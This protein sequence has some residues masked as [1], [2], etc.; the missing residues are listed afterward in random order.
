MPP[1]ASKGPEGLSFWWG[2]EVLKLDLWKC[3][4][5]HSG[6]G[7]FYFLNRKVMQIKEV[8]NICTAAKK[9]KYMILVLCL[10][11]S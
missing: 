11:T 10:A 9:V 7:I 8:K 1:V 4:F 5:L 2:L 6:A 3:V